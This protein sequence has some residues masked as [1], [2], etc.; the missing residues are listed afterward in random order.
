MLEIIFRI[1]ILQGLKG[2]LFRE[3]EQ[4]PMKTICV[5]TMV[6]ILSV[7]SRLFNYIINLQ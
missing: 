3:I 5:E 2:T 1:I 4:Y 6:T 7:V